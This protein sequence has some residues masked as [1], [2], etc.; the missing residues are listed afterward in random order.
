VRWCCY[1]GDRWGVV[2][3]GYVYDISEYFQEIAARAGKI[4]GDP[5]IAALPELSGYVSSALMRAPVG[6]E[7]EMAFDSPVRAPTKV[8]G[9]P[10]NYTDHVAEAA[11]DALLSQNRPIAPIEEAGLFLKAT[12]CLVGPSTGIAIRFPDRRTDHEIEVGV[13]IGEECAGVSVGEAL[14]HVAGYALAI[15]A[16]LRGPEDRS[17]RKSIDTYGVLGPYLVTPDEIGDPHDVSFSLAVNGQVRQSASTKAMIMDVAHLISWASEWY[18]LYPGDVIMTGTPAGA[19]PITPGDVIDCTLGTIA[20]MT[21]R[22]RGFERPAVSVKRD[23][24]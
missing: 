19:G 7:R 10:V 11:S 16:T 21:V 18:T 12:S 5:F 23:M 9:A 8:I 1:G 20:T 3:S 17:F 15:D 4:D 14:Q 2:D 22:V 13:V 24:D 6:P